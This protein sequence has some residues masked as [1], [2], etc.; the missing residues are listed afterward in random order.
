MPG[1]ISKILKAWPYDPRTINAR[2][3]VGED[4][5]LRVQLRLDLGI[6]QM[7]ATGRPDGTRPKGYPS[8]LD[9]YRAQ[10]VARSSAERFLI[11]A[12]ECT[13]L[14]QEVVQYYYRYLSFYALRHHDGVIGDTQHN[15]DIIAL[16]N[17]YGDDISVVDQFLQFYPYVRMMNA[18]ACA[19]KALHENNHAAA[20]DALQKALDEIRSFWAE[21][22]GI[23]GKPVDEL[24]LLANMLRELMK[25][26]PKTP[27]EALQ[28]QLSNAIAEEDYERAAKLRDKLREIGQTPPPADSH[29]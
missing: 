2:W 19:E 25:K 11:T 24:R 12:S 10:A 14:Q 7:E 23:A 15:L 5:V 28:E 20:I 4:G 18:R 6:F 8:L 3:I 27:T 13:D 21:S 17:E 26:K 1:D 16:V 9:Y 22:A 29:S